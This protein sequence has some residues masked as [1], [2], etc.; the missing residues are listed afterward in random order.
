MKKYYLIY[1][2]LTTLFIGI[3]YKIK[4]DYF[5]IPYP[6][7]IEFVLGFILLL[8]TFIIALWKTYRKKKIALGI[9]SIIVL[10][11]IVN[12][13][14]YYFEWH[15]LA[16]TLPFTNTQ[17]CEVDFEPAEWSVAKP[18]NVGLNE[19]KINQYLKEIENWERLRGLIVIKNDKLIVEKYQGGATKYSALNI[20][21]V[22]KSIT[23]AL[24]GLAIQKGGIRSENELVT[25]FFPEYQT[26]ILDNNP[27]K[28][29]TI[30]DLLTMRG[31]F[32]GNDGTENL[33][34]V[35]L[36]R[37]VA[38]ENI[39]KQFNYYTGSHMILSAIIT[40]TSKM[41]TK[42]FAEKNLF[43]PLGMH[44]A[45]W[46]KV[47][48]YYCGGD[49]TYFTPRDLAKFGNLYLRKGKINGV[50][51]LDSSWI[52][53]SFMNH[54]LPPKNIKTPDCYQEIGY[55]FSWW[56][57]KYNNEMI[58]TARGRGG[59]YVMVIPKQNMVIVIV[60]AWKLNKDLKSENEF[61][62][63]LLSLIV[64]K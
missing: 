28:K 57:L 60:Q 18:S 25:S 16:H 46:R 23:S 41:S 24:I 48:G 31:G 59:Q 8:L 42:E 58:Y 50:Q 27:K 52:E 49:Q 33:E 39:G 32:T 4:D 29:I 17:S 56:L 64:K 9:S 22:T 13:M 55:G 3:S 1:A 53:K 36:K 14:N 5:Y 61:I 2:V 15:P 44:N 6:N 35:L 47:D 19:T 54:A 63:K 20:H 7:A 30:A 37:K 12:L 34:E 21:S 11:V 45:F 10:I 26:K 40:K 62:C 43:K 51:L 38:K